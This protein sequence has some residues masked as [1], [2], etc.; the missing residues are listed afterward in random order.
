M[1]TALAAAP[2]TTPVAEVVTI[3]APIGGWNARDALALMP[4]TDAETMV[5]WF[6]EATYVQT[7]PGSDTW[8][9]N[10]SGQVESILSYTGSVLQLFVV[11]DGRIHNA[12][13]SGSASASLLMLSGLANSRFQYTNFAT[14]GGT[15]M[16]IVNGS[17][18]PYLFNGT[19][20]SAM[21]ITLSAS[22]SAGVKNSFVDVYGF[23]Q[24]LFFIP[25]TGRD[26]YY[27]DQVEAIAGSAT[28]YPLGSLLNL[29]GNILTVASWTRDGG[30]G[31]DDYA[32]FI[33]D[34][35]EVAVYTGTDPSS[36]TNWALQGIYRIPKPLGRRCYQKMGGDLIINT[37]GG[38]YPMSI[39]LSGMQPQSLVTD[40]IYPVIADSVRSY[41]SNYG[42]QLKYWPLGHWLILNVPVKEGSK[43]EQYV[44][45]TNTGAWCR[46]TGLT[47]NCWEIFD[48]KL[49]FG[50]NGKLVQADTGSNDDGTN[51]DIDC[52]QAPSNFGWPG[53]KSFKLI[54]PFINSD[55]TTP[56]AVGLNFDF[57]NRSPVSTPTP[58]TTGIPYWGIATWSDPSYQW[59]GAPVPQGNISSAGGGGIYAAMRI[60][61]AVNL[62]NLQWNATQIVF[63]RGSL[64]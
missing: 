7:R 24:R 19:N 22:L 33:T 47:A 43:Q 26:F 63:E 27:M 59:A 35:G 45:N 46:F 48:N 58:D 17:G 41:R 28:R 23:A 38:A 54:R 55:N 15:F 39:V 9:N 37:E 29:G 51:I 14:P 1:R 13:V 8:F 34:Q 64:V 32:V 40:K 21:N 30:D 53:F 56:I 42:W 57:S 16:P 49:F 3:P 36:T 12:T 2:S 10:F 61:G 52:K 5:N 4:Q 18:T 6:P 25:N 62:D 44:M 11:A 50:A 60:K 20:F 31:M